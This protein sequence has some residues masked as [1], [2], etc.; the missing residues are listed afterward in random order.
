[1]ESD[2]LVRILKHSNDLKRVPRTGWVQ[3][4]GIQD[5]ESV[6]AHSYGVTLLAVALAERAGYDPLKLAKLA[7]VHDLSESIVGDIVHKNGCEDDDRI[8]E[9]KESKELVANDRIFG[10]TE[11]RP[12]ADDAVNLGS[13]EA[14]FL[15]ELDKLEMVSQALGYENIAENPEALREF[16]EGVEAK[17]ENPIVKEIFYKLRAKSRLYSKKKGLL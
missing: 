17:I 1:M 9:D 15:K 2:D 13:P 12:Y 3:K 16:W 6:A 5:A 8:R 11:W 10:S 14:K 7:L 4:V